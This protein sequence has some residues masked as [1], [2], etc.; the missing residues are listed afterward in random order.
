MFTY[1]NGELMCEKVK[2]SAI[3]CEVGTPFYVYSQDILLKNFRRIKN[4]F[5]PLNPL[6]AYSVKANSNLSILRLFAREG[7]GFDI[8]SGGEL[9]RVLKAGGLPEKIIYA[10]VGKSI[11]EL[12]L[13]VKNRILMVNLESEA[14]AELLSRVAQDLKTTV[15]VAMRINPDVEAHTHEYITTGKKE[16]KF[17]VSYKSAP[18]I[19]SRVARFPNLDFVGLHVHVGSQIL[20]L[21]AHVDGAKRIISLL[22]ILRSEGIEIRTINIGG[23]FGIGYMDHEKPMNIEKLAQKIIPILK[24]TGCRTILEP[25]RFIV[26]PSGMLV[27]AINYIKSGDQK[28][29][30]IVDA[31]M[32]DLIRPAL[33]KA[34]HRIIPVKEPTTRKKME[35]DIVGPICESADFF[36]KE[37]RLSP[38]QAGDLMAVC[39]AGAYG[40][41]MS[42]NYNTRRRPPEILVKGDRFFIVKKRETYDDLF[43]GE[44][45][46]PHLR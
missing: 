6:I 34:Y 23:G 4:S 35:M 21:S 39:D 15:R 25:G 7:S 37:R 22:S 24:K 33:Y 26:A 32:S 12:A 18:A 36:G 43:N 19:I 17:G 44:E 29:F 14:E 11:E 1:K 20:D 30:A 9:R 10:G 5:S 38:V 27:T 2:L 13:A 45:Y 8:V 40:Y 42:S 28:Q 31:G 16:N 3:A 46:P 41:V